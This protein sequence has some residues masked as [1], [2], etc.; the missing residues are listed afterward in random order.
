MLF[1]AEPQC[2]DECM[3][4]EKVVQKNSSV[5]EEDL[6]GRV[7]RLVDKYLLVTHMKN[8]FFLHVWP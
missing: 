7:N 6:N 4:A 2:G 1:S 8:I 3:D 5:Q